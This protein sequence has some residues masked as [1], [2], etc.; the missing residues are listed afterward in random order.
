MHVC[1]KL[2]EKMNTLIDFCVLRRV[3]VYT[4]SW[5]K[6]LLFLTGLPL[7]SLPTLQEDVQEEWEGAGLL[8]AQLQV[9]APTAPGGPRPRR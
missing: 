2:K 8:R 9:P 7:R 3:R 6:L 5:Y 4:K 1:L